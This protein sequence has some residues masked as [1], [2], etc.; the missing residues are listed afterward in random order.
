VIT[1]VLSRCVFTSR[2]DEFE[3]CLFFRKLFSQK[4]NTQIFKENFRNVFRLFV[5]YHLSQEPFWANVNVAPR[6]QIMQDSVASNRIAAT[7]TSGWSVGSEAELILE[8][9]VWLRRSSK[10]TSSP[11]VL[12]TVTFKIAVEKHLPYCQDNESLQSLGGPCQC[13]L[14]FAF[15]CIR[16]SFTRSTETTPRHSECFLHLP[17]MVMKQ[18][19]VV[20]FE[21]VPF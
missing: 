8:K 5:S 21:T 18:L 7:V 10:K 17:Q 2:G 1:V 12:A 15:L 6:F 4:M 11:R 19:K 9:N 20:S 13:C 14:S 3:I 16:F